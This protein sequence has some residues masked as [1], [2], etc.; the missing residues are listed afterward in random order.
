MRGT[1]IA[2]ETHQSAQTHFVEVNGASFAIRQ[3][4]P[5]LGVPLVMLQRFRGNMD[6]WDP[7]LVDGLAYERPV[8]LFD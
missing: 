4:G 1:G 2:A 6:D 5:S 8:I 7:L 3:I